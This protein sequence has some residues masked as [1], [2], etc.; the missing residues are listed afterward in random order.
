MFSPL[1]GAVSDH[2]AFKERFLMFFALRGMSAFPGPTCLMTLYFLFASK[3]KSRSKALFTTL[4]PLEKSSE[5][6]VTCA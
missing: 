3:K 1:L 6:C 5:V 4:Y 2:T